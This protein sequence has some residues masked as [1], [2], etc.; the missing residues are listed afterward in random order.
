MKNPKCWLA[1]IVAGLVGNVLDFIVQGKLLTNAY[2]AKLDSMKQDTSPGWFVFGDFVAVIVFAWV[3]AR[4]AS[5]FG[6]GAKGGAAAGFYLGVL[7]SFPTYHFIYM[8]VKSYPYPLAWIN[9][10]YGIAWYVVIGAVIGA[11]LQKPAPAA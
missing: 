1:V 4:V 2:Y 7:V 6:A 11:M 5:V 10:L 9:T 3:F 8:T